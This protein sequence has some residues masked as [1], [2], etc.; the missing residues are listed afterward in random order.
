MRDALAKLD[1]RKTTV[2]TGHLCRIQ[3]Q[4]YMLTNICVYDECG[5]NVIGY[6]DHCLLSKKPFKNIPQG[7]KVRFTGKVKMYTRGD[8][9]KD[10][11]IVV[12]KAIKL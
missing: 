12:N 6:V 1:P 9:S 2:F 5:I 4:R 7:S 3:Y 11:T 8:G 10:Y